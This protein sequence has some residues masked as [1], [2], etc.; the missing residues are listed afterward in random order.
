M[1]RALPYRGVQP[2]SSVTQFCSLTPSGLVHMLRLPAALYLSV[3]ALL[4][5]G[6]DAASTAPG[7]TEFPNGAP[8]PAIIMKYVAEDSSSAD[9]VV[10]ASGGYFNL[11]PHGV[12]FPPNAICDPATSGYGVEFWD[13]RCRTLRDGIQIHAEIRYVDGKH[14]VDFTPSL[15][16]K[17]S[18]KSSEWTYMYMRV[19]PGSSGGATYKKEDLNILWFPY[20]GAEGIDESIDD[21]TQRTF[22]HQSGYAVRR[23][24]HFSGYQ[25]H[26]GRSAS[27]SVDVELGF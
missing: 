22:M 3:A 13:K 20:M 25:V 2:T 8:T 26:D 16:F 11:G 24:K 15:R 19:G 7:S 17:P 10:T 23:I 14:I 9:F 12:Y 27:T 1:V 6:C 21:P 4:L 5:A 18:N